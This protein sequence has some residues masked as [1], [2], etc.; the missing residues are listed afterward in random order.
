MFEYGI[1]K[2]ISEQFGSSATIEALPMKAY[3]GATKSQGYRLCCYA[4]YDDGMLYH[5]SCFESYEA[6]YK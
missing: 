6:A 5:C 4:D 2:F 1:K 3:K